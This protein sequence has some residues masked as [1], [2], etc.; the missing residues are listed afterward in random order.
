[1]RSSAEWAS[2]RAEYTAKDKIHPLRAT[3]T[4][5]FCLADTERA[6]PPE[7]ESKVVETSVSD[8]QQTSSKWTQG[9]SDSIHL[10][11]ALVHRE[12]F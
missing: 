4:F 11:P 5:A 12:Q 2:A 1:M 10:P 6:R 8:Y 9:A 3:C 7:F